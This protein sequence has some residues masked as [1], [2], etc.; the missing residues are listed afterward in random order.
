M[1]RT[2]PGRRTP[3]LP[4][5][6]SAPPS[7]RDP[8][9]PGAATNAALRH[10]HRQRLP[11]YWFAH[12]LLLT[13]SGQKPVHWMVGHTLGAAYDQLVAL[14]PLAPLR[15]VPGG[16]RCPAPSVRRCDEFR[17]DPDVIEAFA[18]IESGGRLLA[19]AFRLER[20]RDTRWRCSAVDIGADL[21][22]DA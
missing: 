10:H 9:G 16:T 5:G 15:P 8:R 2:P 6:H 3:P 12:R 13:L 4:R 19:L 22:V 1:T 17:P 20:G 7:R 21:P 11:R 18:R 14:A